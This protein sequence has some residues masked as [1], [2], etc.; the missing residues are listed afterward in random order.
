MIF[1]SVTLGVHL[2]YFTV[3]KFYISHILPL[4]KTQIVLLRW[5]ATVMKARIPKPNSSEGRLRM[6]EEKVYSAVTNML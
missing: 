2:Y 4:V 5:I 1:E 3:G 6:I